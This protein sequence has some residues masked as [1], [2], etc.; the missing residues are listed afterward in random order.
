MVPERLDDNCMNGLLY[1]YDPKETLKRSVDGRRGVEIR[2][3]I[4]SNKG[5]LEW[6]KDIR[7]NWLCQDGWFLMKEGETGS[8]GEICDA[9]GGG[10]ETRHR[11][12]SAGS[13]RM[14]S[15]LLI[16]L[17]CPA[18]ST[19]LRNVRLW[20]SIGIL[21]AARLTRARRVQRWARYFTQFCLFACSFFL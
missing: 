13:S 8:T 5:E 11:L 15:D 1:F 10:W 2:S 6:G 7:K 19:K 9:M 14:K 21:V 17:I 12:R 4:A 16:R 20:T 18:T 3:M